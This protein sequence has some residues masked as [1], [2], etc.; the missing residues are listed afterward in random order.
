MEKRILCVVLG[1]CTFIL[2]TFFENS[3]ASNVRGVTDTSIKVAAILPMTGPAAGLGVHLGNS[4]KNYVRHV[5]DGGG[6]NGRRLSLVLEDDRYSIP[7]AIAAFKKVVYK[8]KVFALIGPGSASQLTILWKKIQKEKLPNIAIPMPEVAVTPFKK[9]IFTIID[10]YPGQVKVLIDYMI[11]DFNLSEPRVGVIYPDTEVGKIDLAPTLERLKK[12]TI[13]PVTKEILNPAAVDASSQVMSLRRYKANC[14][15]HVGTITPTTIALLRDLKKL[16]LDIP[17]FAS[18][19]AMLGEEMNAI[20]ERAKKLYSVH[21]T[22]PWYDTGSGLD[23]MR[24][25]TLKYHP[26]TEKPYR[27]TIYTHGWI[28]SLVLSEGLKRAGRDLNE[29]AFITGLESMENFDTGGLSGPITYNSKSHKGGNSW[30]I[31]RADPVAEKFA[32]LTK[33]RTAD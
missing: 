10:T 23:A 17:V 33:W 4:T 9:Y 27:G 14:A 19:G 2:L 28:C 6:I 8:D 13:K 21:A 20:G 7:P 22:S 3:G 15:V 25:I 12:Y 1:F 26:G 18:W 5:N 29:E 24:K 11:N 16:G 30:K 31:Y 32:P